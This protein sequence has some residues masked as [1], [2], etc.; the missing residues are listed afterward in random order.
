MD[1]DWPLFKSEFKVRDES[2]KQTGHSLSPY[3]K[4]L[5][6]DPG[7]YLNTYNIYMGQAIEL[8]NNNIP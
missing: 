4:A 3:L 5:L 1:L 8:K 2:M 6:S 7:M